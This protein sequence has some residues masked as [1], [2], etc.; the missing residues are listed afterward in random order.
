MAEKKCR[1]CDMPLDDVSNACSCDETICRY[2]CECEPGCDCG[3]QEVK[4]E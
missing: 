2:C 3:C 1:K 4:G